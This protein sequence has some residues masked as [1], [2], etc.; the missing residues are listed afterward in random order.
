LRDQSVRDV[1]TGLYNRRYMLEA[2]RRE[3][4][5]AA[6]AN[7]HVSLL[8]IDV[9]H[10]KTFNDN[11]GHDAGDTVLRNVG[12]CLRQFCTGDDIACRFGGEEFV[13]LL[14]NTAVE[15]ATARAEELRGK[16]ETLTVRYAEANLPR[17]TIS[18]G[19]ASFPASG[20]SFMEVLNV[21]DAALY[22]AKHNGR[23][24]VEMSRG[25]SQTAV[26]ATSIVDAET[27]ADR[28]MLAAEHEPK[29]ATTARRA[30]RRKAQ[31]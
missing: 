19:I 6:R 14:P 28:A 9:D 1:L 15:A 2:A 11:H 10:F 31:A 7:S 23:N 18:V 24:R 16:I 30:A 4:Q 13:M 3:M 29:S 12:E 21:A 20:S 5:R 27:L 8:S 25:T 17:V 22:T 26:V